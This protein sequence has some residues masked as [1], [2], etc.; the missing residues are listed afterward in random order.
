MMGQ[1]KGGLDEVWVHPFRIVCGL[2]VGFIQHERVRWLSDTNAEIDI[3]PESIVRTYALR[4][5]T[6]RETIWA[7]HQEPGG[8]IALEAAGT[9][10][11]R[12]II[13]MRADFRWLWPYREDALGSLRYGYDEALHAVHVHNRSGDFRALY[14][15]D[16]S[17]AA[18][19]VGPY[20]QIDYVDG[21]LHGVATGRNGLALGYVFDVDG[22]EAGRLHFA[23][24][25]T[26]GDLADAE[27]ENYNEAEADAMAEDEAERT[28]RK[29]LSNPSGSYEDV[30]RHYERLLSTSTMVT[31][32][33]P[34]FNDGYRWALVGTDRF[35]ATTP[36]IGTGLMAGYGTTARGWHGGHE[37]SGRPGYAWYFGRDAEWAALAVDGYGDFDH[38][39]EQLELFRRFQSFDGKIFHEMPTSGPVHYDAADSTPLYVI[40]AAH[41]LRASGDVESVRDLWPSIQLAMEFLYKTDTDGDGLIENTHVGHG[42]I[43][44]GK[45]YGAH[46]TLYLAGTWAKALQDAAYIARTLGEADSA[47]R[48]AADADVVVNRIETDF[49]DPDS[50]FYAYGK[51]RDGTFNPEQTILPAVLMYFRL[52]RP[53]R[54][55][56]MLRSFAGADYSTDWGVRIL[57][58]RSAHFSPQGYHYGSVWPLFTGWMALAEYAA[59]RSTQ[60]FTHVM[61][62]VLGYRHWSLGFLEEV[63]NG[64]TY[65][66]AGV[67]AHQCWSQTNV[68]H[69]VYEGLI[70]FFPDAPRGRIRL[71]PRIPA[72]WNTFR[73]D[74]L[75]AGASRIRLEV[76]RAPG[77]TS[78]RLIL[79]KGPPIAI[80]FAP[81]LPNGSLIQ[82]V[83][84]DGTSIE[85]RG[86]G[87][88]GLL[89]KPISIHLDGSAVV[90]LDHQGGLQV[91][92]I[93][94]HPEPGDTSVYP[95][96][97]DASLD[98]GV[99]IIELEGCAGSESDL[100]VRLFDQEVGRIEG[101]SVTDD[102]DRNELRLRTSFDGEA[103]EYIHKTIHIHLA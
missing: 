80:A 12:I 27:A 85:R 3:F 97:L 46:T 23:F 67:C 33:D 37:V 57:S 48:Y 15:A 66:P 76:E 81:E 18:Q 89:E 102:S 103:K 64:V 99:Y 93:I 98:G 28:F 40:L 92:P 79:Q 10:P 14:G 43:E 77:R 13:R 61:N 47:E 82:D 34:I 51:L 91:L 52:L 101:A 72:E 59:G 68:L 73:A 39:K 75:C 26:S 53:D 62:N 2:E 70:G 20:E 95:R 50:E 84:V 5:G 58:A 1:E 29:L 8:V 65:E 35:W 45:L 32:P 9:G 87:R 22:D 44:G 55:D 60:A 71:E 88:T 69:P 4:S 7:A 16:R 6:L 31:T 19:L 54:L 90:N 25:G 24:S 94:P 30:S 56:A 41:Y 78:Y 74:N 100:R 83:Q 36:G 42:W 96:I 86:R 21:R 49:W 11:L 38:V 17:P 63:L